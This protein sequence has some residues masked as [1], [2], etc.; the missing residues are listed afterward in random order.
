MLRLDTYQKCKVAAVILDSHTQKNII[1]YPYRREFI[2]CLKIALELHCSF[3]SSI[4]LWKTTVTASEYNYPGI[5]YS[6]TKVPKRRLKVYESNFA[7]PVISYP[8]TKKVKNAGSEMYQG[9][10]LAA[11]MSYVYTERTKRRKGSD[12]VNLERQSNT[13]RGNRKK[14][15]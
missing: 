1:V 3:R 15:T 8:H 9:C 14:Y 5:L 4:F 11:F 2:K 10:D 12:F 6:H 13:G 7:A